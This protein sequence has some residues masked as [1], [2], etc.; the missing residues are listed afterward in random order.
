MF[1]LE[2][3]PQVY[4]P[5]PQLLTPQQLASTWDQHAPLF[6]RALEQSWQPGDNL[7]TVSKILAQGKAWCIDVT[8]NGQILASVVV[9]RIETKGGDFLNIWLCAGSAIDEW[10]AEILA[11]IEDW[12]AMMNTKGVML[13]G[14]TGWQR[15]LKGYGYHP[16]TIT[17]EKRLDQCH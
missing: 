10:L 1:D 2:E 5:V 15:K 6:E 12:A 17:L 9:E 7:A 13:S 14:R 3:A 16:K 8:M 11:F 4:V